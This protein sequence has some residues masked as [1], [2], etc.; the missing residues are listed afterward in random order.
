MKLTK[1]RLEELYA[2]MSLA[3]L[4]KHLGMARSTLY[5]QMQKLGVARR[6]KSEAQK[7][8]LKA[9]PHQR[10]GKKHSEEARSKIAEGTRRFWDSKEGQAQ[11]KRLGEMRKREWDGRSGKEKSSI[12]NRLQ[13]GERPG[14]GELSKFGKALCDFLENRE[15]LKTGIR[16]TRN[17]TSDIILTSRKVVIELLLPVAVFGE[18]EARDTEARYDQIIGELNDAGYRVVIIID[19]ANTTSQARCSRVYDELCKFF[20]DDHLQSTVIVS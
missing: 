3:E 5:Y 12:V 10:T 18:K 1:E 6:S 14:P 11:R 16:L 19:Q 17:H 15:D 2:T 20:E 8:H 7:R 4:A 13:N 9:A